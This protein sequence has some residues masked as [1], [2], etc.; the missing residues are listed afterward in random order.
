MQLFPFGPSR[1]ISLVLD[2][3]GKEI[4]SSWQSLASAAS[5]QQGFKTLHPVGFRLNGNPR[6]LKMSPS[7]GPWHLLP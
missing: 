3:T 5:T 6:E 2:N 4:N 7:H 1:S